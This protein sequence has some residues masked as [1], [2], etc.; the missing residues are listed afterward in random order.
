[1]T[2]P[3]CG[4]DYQ[5][6]KLAELLIFYTQRHNSA[7]AS[8]IKAHEVLKRKCF[9]ALKLFECTTSFRFLDICSEVQ[10]IIL[11]WLIKY[12]ACE[13]ALAKEGLDS[14][15]NASTLVCGELEILVFEDAMSY[16]RKD[17]FREPRKTRGVVANGLNMCSYCLLESYKLFM[18]RC[19]LSRVCNIRKLVSLP[20]EAIFPYSR[21]VQIDSKKHC[22]ICEDQSKRK[23]KGQG[24]DVGKGH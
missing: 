20:D 24:Q 9:E 15:L 21:Q 8:N 7:S 14:S 4:L 18:R 11:P 19:G 17:S 1:M 16:G 23:E 3:P 5:K 12:V 6:C 10:V 2:L 22:G 13:F